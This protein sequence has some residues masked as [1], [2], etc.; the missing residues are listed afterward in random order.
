MTALQPVE[1]RVS[2]ETQTQAVPLSRHKLVD[3]C[4]PDEAREAIGRIFC[5]HVLIPQ[6]RAPENFHARHHTAFHTDYSVNYVTY[7]STVDID[8]GELSRFFLLQMPIRG[9]AAVRCGGALAEVEMGVRASILSP[10]LP[11]RMTWHEGCEKIIILIRREALETQFAALTHRPGERIEFAT[12]VDLTTPSGR[13][14][15]R[16]VAL[17]LEAAEGGPTPEAYMVA[18]RD[19]LTTLLLTSLTRRAD[20]FIAEHADR[21]I[22]MAEVAAAAGTSLRSLQDAYRLARGLTLT[23]SIRNIRLERFRAMLEDPEGSAS[24]TDI[25]FTVGFGHLGRAAAVYRA[26]FGETPQQTLRRRR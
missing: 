19:G 20:A 7:T 26:R 13:A 17:M 8:P 1:R 25:A 24:V 11:T 10:T 4:S 14:L 2:M 5:P 9:G 23:E 15:S 16:H 12:G 3:T 22:S 18:L 6:G 21:P